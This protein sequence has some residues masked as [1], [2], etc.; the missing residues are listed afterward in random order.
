[1]DENKKKLWKQAIKWPLYS[2]AILPVFISGAYLLNQYEKV[3]IYNLIAFTLAAILILLWE[4]LTNDLFDAETGIDE[5]KFHSIVKLIENKK[6]IS[7]IA[8]TSLVIGL[9]IISI[10]SLS[11]SIN[12]LILVAGCCFLGY[13]YQGPPFR[14]GYQGLG[15]PLC[16]LA[17]GPF[18]YSAALLA[19]NP[20]NIYFLGT[21]WK[22]SLLLG[23]GPSL[24]TT[25]VLFCSHFHQIIEDKKHGKTSPLVRLGAKKGS[26]LVPWIIFTI[27]IFQLFTI[28]TGFIPVFCV[29]YLISFTQAIKLIKLLN[30]SYNKP[31]AIKNCKFI[32]IKFQTLNGVGLISGLIFNYLINK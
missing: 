9:L 29:L 7:S 26:Q 13:L 2:V 8:Y 6:I 3:K 10:I 32:A 15:E 18:A 31:S 22:E 30:S 11:T 28:I 12:I 23:S 21:P 5:F 14:F 27:Y 17:F 20:S 1:M 24:A 25:L 4:N 16:W 19:L